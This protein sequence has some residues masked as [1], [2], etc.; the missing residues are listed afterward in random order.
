MLGQIQEVSPEHLKQ[1]SLL[2]FSAITLMASVMSTIAAWFAALRCRH[3]V[4]ISP[5]PNQIQEASPFVSRELFN[6]AQ[7]AE[8]ERA[9]QLRSQVEMVQED[10]HQSK[11]E[12]SG[13]IDTLR[14]EI[15]ADISDLYQRLKDVEE[16]VGATPD[17]VVA[18]LL[19]ARN[20]KGSE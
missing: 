20:L 5:H 15:R 17:R 13:K 4:A 8:S 19:N 10:S 12:I 2:I 9:A 7:A 11:V 3:S 16:R 6:Q 18:L 14:L 1:S